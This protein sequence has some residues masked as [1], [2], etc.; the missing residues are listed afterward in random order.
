MVATINNL[1]NKVNTMKSA[2]RF[3]FPYSILQK[4]KQE[5]TPLDQDM[6]ESKDLAYIKKAL[7]RSSS[8]WNEQLNEFILSE[9]LLYIGQRYIEQCIYRKSSYHGRRAP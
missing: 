6:R 9:I 5:E 2:E 4:T 8:E 3:Y 1:F 7:E